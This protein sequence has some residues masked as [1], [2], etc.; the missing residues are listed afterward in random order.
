MNYR[1]PLTISKVFETVEKQ[2]KD[3]LLTEELHMPAQRLSSVKNIVWISFEDQKSIHNISPEYKIIYFNDVTTNGSLKN[4]NITLIDG[5]TRFTFDNEKISD[6]I[7]FFRSGY[8]NKILSFFV[9]EIIDKGYLVVNDPAY[10]EQTSNKY[11]TAKLFSE[12]GIPQP[13]Y[14]LITKQ[15][16]SIE[17]QKHIKDKLKEIYKDPKDESQYICKI[18][19]GHG[20]TGVFLCHGKNILSVLQCLFAVNPETQILVQEKKEIQDGDIRVHIINLNGKQVIV[21][22]IMRHHSSDDFRTNQS[23]GNTASHYDLTKDQE[24]L[25]KEIAKVSGLIWAGIDI[26]PATDGKNYAIEIN[27]SGGSSVDINDPELI[28]KNTEFFKNIIDTIK[29]LCQK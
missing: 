26:L 5:D 18:L 11:I 19:S 4:G 22:S 15:D 23:L 3:K 10:V 6:T 20:G 28:E 27:G 2:R 9:K 7:V 16:V 13:N 17:N 25:A 12:Q 24:K 8:K 21:D 14:C 1:D 29:E